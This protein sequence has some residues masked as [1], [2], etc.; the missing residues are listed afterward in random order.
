MDVIC[1]Q[2]AREESVDEHHRPNNQEV[3]F[4]MVTSTI[5]KGSVCILFH[6]YYTIT[7]FGHCLN[8]KGIM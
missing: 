1:L 2:L 5:S 7:A 8:L 6:A 4:D 3:N